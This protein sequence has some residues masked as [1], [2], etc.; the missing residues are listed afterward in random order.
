[1]PDGTEKGGNIRM[2]AR[3][4][5]AEMVLK[6]KSVDDVCAAA[7]FG[8]SSW[9]RKISGETE[10]TQ[11]EI[12]AISNLLSLNSEQIGSIFFDPEVS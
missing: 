1:M 3:K 5:K 7:G 6:D 10:F 2:N 8:R 12:S 11:G 4:L 9:F